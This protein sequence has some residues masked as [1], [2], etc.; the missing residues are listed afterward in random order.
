[1]ELTLGEHA[2]KLARFFLGGSRQNRVAVKVYEQDPAP[3]AHEAP[4]RHG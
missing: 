3:A 2:G 4:R 1:M